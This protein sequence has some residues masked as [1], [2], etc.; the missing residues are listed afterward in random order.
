MV[1]SPQTDSLLDFVLSLNKR[2]L[3]SR[4][5]ELQQDIYSLEGRLTDKEEEKKSILELYHEVIVTDQVRFDSLI[6]KH[7]QILDSRLGLNQEVREKSEK[8]PK[9]VGPNRAQFLDW[10]KKRRAEFWADKIKQVEAS[11]SAKKAKADK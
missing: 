7:N 3:R 4:V 10:E 1:D 5:I 9:P 6:E 8:P 2:Q 11:D